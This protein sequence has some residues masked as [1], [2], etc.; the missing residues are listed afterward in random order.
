MTTTNHNDV[1]SNRAF[2]LI[3]LLVVIAIIA[4]LAALLLPT[5]GNGKAQARRVQCVSQLQQWG[6]ALQ[7][8]SD[9]NEDATPRRGQGV[10]PLTKLDRPEDWFNALPPQM[11][12]EGSA[13]TSLARGRMQIRL[14]P[15]SSAPKP[16]PHRIV[17]F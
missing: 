10:R 5:L 9:E 4:V 2:S 1:R 13:T 17:I 12:I 3:E 14:P 11:G 16:S 6:K 15:C 8:Y 7:M